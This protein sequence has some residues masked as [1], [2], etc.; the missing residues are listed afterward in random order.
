VNY[1]KLILGNMLVLVGSCGGVVVLNLAL[2]LRIC[3]LIT[4]SVQ[5]LVGKGGVMY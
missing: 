5:F 4:G 3:E 2:H 1:N